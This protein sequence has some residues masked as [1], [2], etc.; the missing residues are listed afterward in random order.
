MGPRVFERLIGQLYQCLI[1]ES[2][3]IDIPVILFL[4]G[5]EDG[6]PVSPPGTG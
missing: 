3:A 4:G 1:T 6:F 5:E 2:E